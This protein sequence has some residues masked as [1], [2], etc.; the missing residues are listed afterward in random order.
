MKFISHIAITNTKT[1]IAMIVLEVKMS[2]RTI[3]AAVK[4]IL[5][6]FERN[7]HIKLTEEEAKEIL[8]R[9]GSC[10]ALNMPRHLLESVIDQMIIGEPIPIE[11]K[12]LGH[13]KQK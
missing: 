7:Y 9:R 1:I 6:G 4:L 3:D 10:K 2:D 13:P 8:G 11:W 5:D 12:S